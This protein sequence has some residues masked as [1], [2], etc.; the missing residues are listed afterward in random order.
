MCRFRGGYGRYAYPLTRGG[1]WIAR[2]MC[3]SVACS[4][5]TRTVKVFLYWRFHL[6][7]HGRAGGPLVMPFWIAERDWGRAAASVERIVMA[8]WHNAGY[9]VIGLSVIDA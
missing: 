2:V 4:R 3:N 5:V 1:D 6:E 9:R 8:L 7:D